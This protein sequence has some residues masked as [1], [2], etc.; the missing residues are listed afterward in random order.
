MTKKAVIK[1]RYNNSPNTPSS[2]TGPFVLIDGRV[3]PYTPAQGTPA[4]STFSALPVP[5]SVPVPPVPVP[6]LTGPFILID[7]VARPFEPGMVPA[8]PA[9]TS[10]GVPWTSVAMTGIVAAVVVT[11]MVLGMSTEAIV[12]GVVLIVL[13]ANH[14]RK[15]LGS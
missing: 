11:F 3:F 5:V 8:P 12:S 1:L 4:G 6:T 15:S 7:G 9:G 14:V 10:E 2:G 13:L